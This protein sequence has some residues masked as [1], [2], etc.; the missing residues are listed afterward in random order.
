MVFKLRV[1]N[2]LAYL[3]SDRFVFSRVPVTEGLRL[4]FNT[5]GT[6]RVARKIYNGTI[7]SHDV[8]DP[9][10]FSIGF[11]LTVGEY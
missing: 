3:G 4:F 9:M 2:L 8:S 7:G 11:D 1:Y 10:S 5:K 6:V